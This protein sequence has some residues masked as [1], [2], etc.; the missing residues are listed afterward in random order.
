MRCKI[1]KCKR[2]LP[3][4]LR[5]YTDFIDITIYADITDSLLDFYQQEPRVH[6]GM[7][8]VVK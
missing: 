7:R 1:R 2:A 8:L 6:A 4:K 5:K 3:N